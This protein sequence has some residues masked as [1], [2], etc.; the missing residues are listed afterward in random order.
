MPELIGPALSAGVMSG[1]PQPT[2]AAGDLV[3]RPW[4]ASDIDVIV[5]A[6]RDPSIQRWHVRSMT[7]DEASAWIQKYA[8]RWD[9]ETGAGW[10]VET[11]GQVIGR[12]GLRTNLSSGT[13][14]AGYWVMPD[15]RGRGVAT[16]VLMAVTDWAFT[17]VGLHRVELEHST[18][19]EASCRVATKAGFSAEGTKR[20][21]G[22]HADGWHD[23]HVH[24]R[25][26]GS[27]H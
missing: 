9:A 2:I 6:Y 10:A 18:V 5:E 17:D 26:N 7:T 16:R 14:E 3:L 12:V 20:S 24:A 4:A 22:R 8:A 27:A 11:D 25:I 23:M 13:A 1:T 19:N 21:S 15:A